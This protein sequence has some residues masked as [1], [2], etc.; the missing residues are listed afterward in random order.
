MV[1]ALTLCVAHITRK[2]FELEIGVGEG[3]N[4]IFTIIVIIVFII[5]I[6]IIIT[7]LPTLKLSGSSGKQIPMLSA[8]S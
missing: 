5:V 8:A 1:C 2:K 3:R 4:I 7:C 6:I